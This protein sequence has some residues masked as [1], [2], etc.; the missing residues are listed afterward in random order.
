MQF[1]TPA[2]I[3]STVTAVRRY[4]VAN[5]FPRNGQKLHR[6]N[7]LTANHNDR[8]APSRS[9][10][11]FQGDALPFYGERYRRTADFFSFLFFF[12]FF[13]ISTKNF[14]SK[15]KSVTNILLYSG[16]GGER[17]REEGGFRCKIKCCTR[18]CNCRPTRFG[19]E[20]V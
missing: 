8:R 10:H 20:T 15:I 7:L 6:G 1:P 17:E 14:I 11:A 9:A 2:S 4:I 3:I 13:S 19:S 16:G 5:K 12:S 18:L